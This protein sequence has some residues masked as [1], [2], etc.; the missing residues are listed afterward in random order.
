MSWAVWTLTL[1]EV[2]HLPTGSM[3]VNN[4]SPVRLWDSA[5]DGRPVEWLAPGQ[6]TWE[7]RSDGNGDAVTA[8]VLWVYC[9]SVHASVLEGGGG[10]V[11]VCVCVWWCRIWRSDSEKQ[12]RSKLRQSNK[13]QS[14]HMIW[15][16]HC[17]EMMAD[18]LWVQRRRQ[19]IRRNKGRYLYATR[20]YEMPGFCEIKIYYIFNRTR[21]QEAIC[22]RLN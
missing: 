1:T 6:G 2:N 13:C 18:V 8:T 5:M 20:W 15:H 12:P 17:T 22:Y 10:S 3:G 14:R 21:N 11:C 4:T 9:G 16:I 7:W 19:Q